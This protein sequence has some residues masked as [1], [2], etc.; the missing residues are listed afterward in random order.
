MGEKKSLQFIAC[1]K[2]EG[3]GSDKNGL[4]CPN[5]SGLGVGVFYE[6]RFLFWGLKY[7]KAVIKLRH[8]YRGVE[9]FIKMVFFTIGLIGLLSLGFYILTIDHD[10]VNIFSIWRKKNIWLLFFWIGILAEMFVFYLLNIDEAKS[11]KI[12]I[13]QPVNTSI[14]PNNWAELSSYKNN[15]DVSRAYHENT[16]LLIENAFILAKKYKHSQVSTKHLLFALL[17]NNE[18]IALFIRL[19]INLD[20]LIKDLNDKLLNISPT[21][22]SKIQFS[23]DSLEVLIESFVN[24][25][26]LESNSVQALHL[27]LPIIKRDQDVA[28][29]FLD[30]E[31]SANQINNT[32][33]WFAINDKLIEDYKIYKKKASLKPSKHMDRAYTAVATPILD[34]FG[35]DLTLAAK[36]RRLELCINRDLEIADIF[37]AIE[38]GHNGIILVGETGVGKQTLI[39]GIAQKMVREDVP[40]FLKDKRLVELDI[41]R[42]VSGVKPEKIE[43]RLLLIIDEVNKAQNIILFINNIENLIGITSGQ[44]ASLE[45]SDILAN[46]LE[47]GYLICLSVATTINYNQFI[48]NKHLGNSLH[49]ILVAEPEDD[50]AIQILESKI[51]YLENK[52]NIYFSYRSIEQAV[53][54]SKKYI[55]EKFLP[56]KAIEIVES[57]ALKISEKCRTDKSGCICQKEDIAEEINKITNIPVQNITA[58]EGEKL[59]NLENDIHQRMIN[60]NEAVKMV[61]ASLRRARTD[62]REEKK[63]IASFLFLGPTGVGKTELAKTV[64]EIYF[65]SEKNMIRLDMSEYQMQENIKKMIGD[66]DGTLGYL[67]EAVRKQSFSLILLDEFEKAHPDVLNIFLQVL[68]DGRLTDGQG[69]TINFTNSIIIATSN[70][71]ALF[72]QEQIAKNIDTEEIKTAL[73]NEHLTKV[74]RPELINRFNGIVVFKPLTEQNI[75]DITV[76]MLNRIEKT[77]TKKGMYF[78]YSPEGVKEIA[79]LGYDPKFGARQL[80]RLIQESIENSI[81]DKILSNELKIRDTVYLNNQAVVEIIKAK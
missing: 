78:K 47:K 31:I 77:L 62:M 53:Y 52:Y 57:C 13:Y 17:K 72:I 4:S 11:E 2:C 19:E 59:L 41:S 64:A 18:I 81:A 63:P 28:D 6:D 45:L 24:A 29:L 80:S 65:G 40:K 32:I 10:K 7:G 56:Q 46:S 66:S 44:E 9:M 20:K 30:Q 33:S 75:F 15:F 25:Y 12:K 37:G 1:P 79:R 61:A 48:E 5:C 35:Y 27:L 26:K 73:I 38:S 39:N 42:L 14:L 36:W 74:L 34:H 55:T 51:G 68:D 21:N 16:V 67:T 76:L 3:L 50:D 60:Q 69:R 54:L 23:L 49:K 43:E 8:L 58:Q 70:I 71:G 22:D